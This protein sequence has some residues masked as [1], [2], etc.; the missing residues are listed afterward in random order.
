MPDVDEYAWRRRWGNNFYPTKSAA[1]V[2]RRPAI[3]K[4]KQV[5]TG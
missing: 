2:A 5:A 3:L 4:Q 1:Y